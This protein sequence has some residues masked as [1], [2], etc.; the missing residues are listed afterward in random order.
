MKR[1]LKEDQQT[2]GDPKPATGISSSEGV[3]KIP[4]NPSQNA[5]NPASSAQLPFEADQSISDLFE[6]FQK[7]ATIRSALLKA[8]QNPSVSS[9]KKI[10]IEKAIN[11]LNKVNG[12]LLIIPQILSK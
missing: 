5:Q 6:M 8:L 7:G 10:A 12:D 3:V 1:F 9:V 11:R 2:L 4:F